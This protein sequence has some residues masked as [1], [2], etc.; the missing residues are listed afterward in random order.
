LITG[1]VSLVL[2][3]FSSLLDEEHAKI[4][5]RSSIHWCVCVCVCVCVYIYIYKLYGLSLRANYTDR[6]TATCW[7]SEYQLLRIEGATRSA[8]QI[9][10]AVFSAF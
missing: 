9:P 10:T 6:A 4:K 7:R 8:W 2:S 3:L 5:P 1:S